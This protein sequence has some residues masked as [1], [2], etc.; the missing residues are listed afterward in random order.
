MATSRCDFGA[1]LVSI[2]VLCTALLFSQTA[3]S[4]RLGNVRTIVRDPTGAVIPNAEVTFRGD[5][6]VAEKTTQDG[7]IRVQ[8]PCGLYS[9]TVARPGFT[10][11]VDHISIQASDAPDLEVVLQLAFS[12]GCNP[13]FDVPGIEPQTSVLTNLIEDV[14]VP[15]QETALQIAEPAL[16]KTYGKRKIDYEKPLRAVLDG[17]IWTVY[18]TLCCP[19]S[20]GRR[21]CEVGRCFG[22]VATLKIRESDGKILAIYHTR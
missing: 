16:I 20:K 3:D 1:I 17:G 10:T 4:S 15:D 11:S 13:C 12:G 21:T 14:R 7:S 8:L 6:T 19:D 9:V 22:G 5:K 18:G 2:V